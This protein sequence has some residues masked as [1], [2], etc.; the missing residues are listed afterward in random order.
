MVDSWCP[1]PT[2]FRVPTQDYDYDSGFGGGVS[3]DG[4]GKQILY[5]GVISDASEQLHR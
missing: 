2:R 1:I 3:D 5:R 4:D